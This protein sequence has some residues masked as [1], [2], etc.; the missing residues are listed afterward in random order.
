MVPKGGTLTQKP[1]LV[2]VSWTYD[3]SRAMA[4]MVA[5]A[6]VKTFLGLAGWAILA[7][8]ARILAQGQHPS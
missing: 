4:V 8:A 7:A 6:L 3:S 5:T 1:N 2:G